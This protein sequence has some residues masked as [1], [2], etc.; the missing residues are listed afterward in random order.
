MHKNKLTFSVKKDD[1]GGYTAQC[2]E[3]PG[4]ITEGDTK[5]K[6]LEM[7]ND[8]VDGYFEAFPDEKEKQFSHT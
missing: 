3:F 5:R 2:L 8:A 6:L 7:I 4:I 1:D